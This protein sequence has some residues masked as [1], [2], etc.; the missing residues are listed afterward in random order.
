MHDVFETVPES[1]TIVLQ[2][3]VSQAVVCSGGD[4]RMGHVEPEGRLC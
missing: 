3:E 4:L 1:Q 2:Q